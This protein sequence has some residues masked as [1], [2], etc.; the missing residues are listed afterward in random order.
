MQHGVRLMSAKS[1]LVQGGIYSPRNNIN[2]DVA[3][4]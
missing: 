2:N 4:P 3:S 1:D